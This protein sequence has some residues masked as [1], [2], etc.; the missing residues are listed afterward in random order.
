[1][2]SVAP[3]FGGPRAALVGFVR[4]AA[5]GGWDSTVVAPDPG[6][7]ERERLAADIDDVRF[8]APGRPWSC[9]RALG[10][11][12]S[13]ADVVHV[14]GTLAPASSTGAWRAILAGRPLVVR[15]FGTLSRYTFAGRRPLLK[16][17]YHG[18]VDAPALCRA[19]VVHFT[20]EAER[21]EALRLRAVDAR[22]SHVVPPPWIPHPAAPGDSSEAGGAGWMPSATRDGDTVLF[23]AR[24]DPKKGVERLLGAWPVVRQRRPGAR[25]IIAGS[26]PARYRDRVES[27][28]AALAAPGTGDRIEFT[29]FVTG[30]AKAALLAR[31]DV[32]VLP[33]HAENFGVAVL[34]ALAAGLPVVVTPEVG[35]A[36]FVREHGLGRV[37]SADPLA[38]GCALADALGNA[39]MRARCRTRGPSAV[40][41]VFGA[42]VVARALGRMYEAALAAGCP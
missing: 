17:L 3:T 40:A 27:R 33:S 14:H 21:D 6:P 12:V 11:L 20:T 5:L 19:G 8:W 16:R 13:T 29:G 4:A 22:R 42:E 41:D 34:E 2:P 37:T 39:E 24:L 25:L 30:S 10:P 18:I 28:A 9:W 35:L 23:L 32:F 1:M 38:L 26:G 15:P 7:G 36:G 31:A